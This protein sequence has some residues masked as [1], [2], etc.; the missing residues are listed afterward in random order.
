[1]LADQTDGQQHNA[2]RL[3][4][5]TPAAVQQTVEVDQAYRRYAEW[6]YAH[7][8]QQMREG[9]ITPRRSSNLCTKKHCAFWRECVAEYG[10]SV[11]E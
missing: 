4:T 6:I 5:M 8:Q 11:R 3:H 9:A 7:A 2:V 1:M 10:G